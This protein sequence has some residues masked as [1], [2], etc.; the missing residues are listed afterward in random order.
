[1]HEPV[2]EAAPAGQW[3]PE[4]AGALLFA[5]YAYAPN[6]RGTCGPA[7]HRE[8]LEYG[9]HRVADRGLARLATAFHGAWPYL[10]LIAGA[11]GVGDP[12][13][14]RVV[15]AYWVG[16]S[17]LDRVDRGAF[18]ESVRER[19]RPRCGSGWAGLAAT[20]PAGGVPH[21]SY[22]VFG[23]YPW[24]GLLAE[25]HRGEPL[26][27]LDRCRIRWGQVVTVTG[28]QAV[29][30]SQPLRWDGA[31]LSLGAFEAERVTVA[32]A[33]LGFVG[34]LRPGE[35]VAAHWDWVC[36]RL[37]LR[38][39]ANLRHYTHRMLAMTNDRLARPGPA[40]ALG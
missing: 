28:D 15:E 7:D 9:A 39:R 17:L 12:L 35:W 40:A 14:R 18:G 33:G 30:S 27:I 37:S 34:D 16:N 11:T 22:H 24:I 38:Q 21:H 32:R 36:D 20:V 25:R 10:E 4:G 1:M 23:V 8:V 29:I 19:F 26:Q 13:D 5:R 2:A 6:E 3:D 31:R